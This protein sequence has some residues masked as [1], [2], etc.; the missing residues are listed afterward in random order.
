MSDLNP[1]AVV[2]AAGKGERF[3]S[4]LKILMPIDGE[5]MLGRTVRVLLNG[6]V[7][8]VVIVVAPGVDV[9]PIEVLNDSRVST[10]TNPDPSRG[11][12]SSIQTGCAGVHGDPVL[13][14]PADMPFVRSETVAALIAASRLGTL[15]SPRYRSR[16][17]HPVALPGRLRSEI[18]EASPTSTLSQLLER[19]ESDRLDLD[20]DD[21]GVLRDVDRKE[22]L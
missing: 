20:V 18:L 4:P 21:P 5:P 19:H 13:V 1:C 17:G 8:H 14:L 3:G 15:V 10:I 12:F 16:R 6:G 2:P 11:M 9:S 22:D 7:E